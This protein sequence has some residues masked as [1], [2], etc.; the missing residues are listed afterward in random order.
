M[1]RGLGGRAGRGI[2]GLAVGLLLAL[3]GPATALQS[4]TTASPAAAGPRTY[5][6]CVRA[7]AN[8]PD[9]QT[10]CA[11]LFPATAPTAAP[12][13]S[14]PSTTT[15]PASTSTPT[16]TTQPVDI[17]PQLNRLFDAWKNR[18]KSTPKPPTDPLAVIPGILAGC[19][20]YTSVP[21]RWRRCTLDGWRTAGFTGT[22]PLVLQSPPVVEPPPVVQPPVT[23]PTQPPVQPPV[24][25]SKPPIQTPAPLTP[26]TVRS[27]PLVSTPAATPEP[28][29]TAIVPPAPEPPAAAPPPPPAPPATP[30]WFWLLALVAAAGVGFGVAKL[31]GRTREPPSRPSK[32]QAALCIPEIALVADPGVVVVTPDGPPGAGL[33]VSLRFERAR[34]GEIGLDYPTL[35]TTP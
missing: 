14:T 20:D 29:P 3:A 17:T 32:V 4:T 6:E 10:T 1:A 23:P 21:E 7:Y 25:V 33:A 2:G 12:A 35:E 22:P 27:E 15:A 31:A 16:Q 24:V 19:A 28:P 18:P 26:E 13:A 9:V 8:R 5:T 30:I 34:G 11:R